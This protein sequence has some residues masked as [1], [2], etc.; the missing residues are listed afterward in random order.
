MMLC[1]MLLSKAKL[2][3]NLGALHLHPVLAASILDYMY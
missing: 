1:E 3:H 2:R